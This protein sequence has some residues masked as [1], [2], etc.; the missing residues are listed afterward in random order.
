MEQIEPGIKAL[1]EVEEIDLVE[2]KIAGIGPATIVRV[3][4]DRPG[5]VSV[6][7]CAQISRRISDY[8]DARD[9]I[10]HKYKLEVSSPGLDRPLVSKADFLRKKG[11]KVTLYFKDKTDP[12]QRV[13]GVISSVEAE[14]LVLDAQGEKHRIPLSLIEK[15][16]IAF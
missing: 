4:V 16:L 7:Q 2:L 12:R 1:V 11:E 15:A 6:D 14:D 9:L 10:P 8:L 13:Q 5:G 3:Y